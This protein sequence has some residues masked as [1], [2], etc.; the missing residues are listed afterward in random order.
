MS[1]SAPSGGSDGF[2]DVVDAGDDPGHVRVRR[3]G[4]VGR[5]TLDR[6]EAINAL[7]LRMMAT[8]DTVLRSWEAD[9]Q[10][11]I[12]VLDG[13]GRRG[14]CAGGD[15]RVIYEDAQN[16]RGVSERLWRTEYLLD[17]LIADY[18]K[19]VVTVLDVI[20]MGGGI[21]IGCHIRHRIVT[22][23]SVLALPEVALGLAPDVG[24]LLLL[25]RAPGRLGAHL[26][27]T[28]ARMGGVDAVRAGFADAV[29]PSER[30]GQ[31][32]PL[33]Q[34]MDPADAIATLAVAPSALGEGELEAHRSWIDTCYDADVVPAVVERLAAHREPAARAA[35]EAI[36]RMSPLAL[37]VTWCGLDE[38]RKA[39]ALGPTLVQD[40][41]VSYRFLDGPDLVEGI[42]AAVI[43]KSRSPVWSPG[44]LIDVTQAM[45]DR[46]F[47][48][49]G[50]ADL[51]LSPVL[52][53]SAG[54]P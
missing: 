43:D 49:L 34:R 17:A 9:P 30:L 54:R 11:D 5:L 8:L 38:A 4:R 52:G 24:G 42:R 16:R 48:P 7:S 21:G 50:A 22:E 39:D 46:H 27:L 13:T 2:V 25:A 41:R 1:P 28:A 20:T 29:V 51:D 10:I 31:L 37:C 19:P 26:A 14:F 15:I 40:L 45:V 32:V 44:R 35:A 47:A 3:H 23:R 6:P 33:L 53:R 36:T 12:V 18:R